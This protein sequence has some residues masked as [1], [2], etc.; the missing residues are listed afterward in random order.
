MSLFA[1]STERLIEV[2]WDKTNSGVFATTI[3]VRALDR[4]RLLADVTRL[5]AE[6]H[7][8]ILSSSSQAGSD[9]ISRMRFEFEL[10]DPS[11]LDSVL[12]SIKKLDSVYDAYRLVPRR[13]KGNGTS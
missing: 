7:V 1:S 4:S 3:E 10:A 13:T 6:H 5:L 12:V 2:E 11:H 8:N 9:R